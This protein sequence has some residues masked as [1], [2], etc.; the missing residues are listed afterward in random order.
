MKRI[1]TITMAA[2][3]LAMMLVSC[4]KK[5]DKN[6]GLGFWLVE[7]NN[8]SLKGSSNLYHAWY[9]YDDEGSGYSVLFLP[10][11]DLNHW[12]DY[13]YAYVDLAESKV[14][15]EHN[16]ADDLV[17]GFWSFYSGTKTIHVANKKYTGKVFLSVNREKNNVIFRLDGTSPD[18]D[19]V[20][21]DYV[22]YA[23]PVEERPYPI[24]PL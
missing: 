7:S 22:G 17:D 21:I 6:T 24:M 16:L 12:N 9:Y 1:I 20:K 11:D 4:N 15:T 3:A 5:G 8:A 2:L 19:K 13:D 10:K 18:G 14:G 23:S